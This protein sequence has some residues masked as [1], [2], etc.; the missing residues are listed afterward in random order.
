MEH[1]PV[2]QPLHDAGY[3][4]LKA[5][6]D[7]FYNEH[8]WTRGTTMLYVEQPLGT[9]FSRGTPLPEN[10]LD[11]SS[12]LWTFMTNFYQVFEHLQEYDFYIFGESYAGM[13]VP[14][15]AHYF[16]HQNLQLPDPIVRLKGA[17]IGN[18]WMDPTVQGPATI[19]YSWWHGLIDA[20]TR[21]ALHNEWENCY[22]GGRPG[23][24]P[25]HPLNVQDD[26]GIMWGILLAAGNPNAYDITTWDPN[27]DQV[28]FTS[29]AFYNRED[30]KKILHAP[31]GVT[32]HG[33]RWGEGRRRLSVSGRALHPSLEG[34]SGPHG[35]SSNRRLQYMDNDRPWSVVPYVADLVDHGIPVLVY[36]GDRDMTT[37][38]VGSELLLNRMEW[39]GKDDWLDAPRGV[40]KVDGAVAGWAKEHG[41]LKFVVVYNSGHM[42]SNRNDVLTRPCVSPMMGFA[43]KKALLVLTVLG[44]I[45]RHQ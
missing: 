42:V 44:G 40:W 16:Y 33:C 27:V 36:N 19:D 28:T 30:V 34:G 4:C 17:A 12:D 22:R 10:E 20:P 13:F 14:S 35:S 29:E 7:L 45:W 37:N 23:G 32:W 31:D 39:S 5:T 8:A 24:G 9:G 21:D 18:G 3:C 38:M 1:S 6:P 25:F 43:I 41:N 2:T 26:C 11:V 15:V